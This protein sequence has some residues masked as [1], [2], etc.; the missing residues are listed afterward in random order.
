MPMSFKQTSRNRRRVDVDESIEGTEEDWTT[1]LLAMVVAVPV[2]GLSLYLGLVTVVMSPRLAAYM[3]LQVP[4]YF[5]VTYFGVALFVGLW[6]GMNG[7][8]SLLGHLF[9]T[10]FANQAD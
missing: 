7:I 1:R 4:L 2:F 5:H 8:T 6:F 3:L 10:H 9:G